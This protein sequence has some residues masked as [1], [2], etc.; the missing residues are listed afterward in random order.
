MYDFKVCVINQRQRQLTVVT[1][2]KRQTLLTF[3]VNIIDM[4]AQNEVLVDFRLSKGDGL[5]FKKIFMK[6]KSSLA[7]VV[8]KRYVFVNSHACCEKRA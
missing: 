7:P 6:I 2:D 1:S 8:C 5:E 4:N 3:K